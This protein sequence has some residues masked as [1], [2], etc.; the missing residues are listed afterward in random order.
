MQP[1]VGQNSY[2]FDRTVPG[3]ICLDDLSSSNHDESHEA[4]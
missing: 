1:K 3:R 4:G 2:C